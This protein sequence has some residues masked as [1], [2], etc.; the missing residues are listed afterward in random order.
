M[1]ENLKDPQKSVLE[2]NFGNEKQVEYVPYSRLAHSPLKNVRTKKATG[3]EGLA[4]SIFAKG[5]LQ[6]LVVHKLDNSHAKTA[7]LGVCAGARRFAALELL[8]AAGKIDATF[9]VPV[10]VVSPAEALAASLIENQQR[11]PM[12]PAD[13]AEAFAKLIA[14]GKSLD[15]VAA[16]FSVSAMTVQRRIKLAGISPKLTA[17]FRNDEITLEQI[18]A[19]AMTDDHAVQER[20]WFDAKDTWQRQPDRLRSAITNEEMSVRGKLVKFIGLDA[21]EFAG[22]SV[23]RDLFSNEENTGFIMDVEL[24]QNLVSEKLVELAEQVR[25]EG[26]GWAETRIERDFNEIAK[27]GRL[28]QNTKVLTAEQQTELDTLQAASDALTKK[29]SDLDE[30]DEDE[31]QEIEENIDLANAAIERFN[32]SL[33][34]FDTTAMTF[35]G[36]FIIISHSGEAVIE[37]GLVKK[38]NVEDLQKCN[39]EISGFHSQTS[40]IDDAPKV[41]ALHGEKLCK[42]LT[43]HRTAALQVELAARPDVALAVLLHSMVPVVFSSE[44]RGL[45]NMQ[46]AQV[47]GDC[48]HYNLTGN[49]DDMEGS[50]AWELIAVDRKEWVDQLPKNFNELMLWLLQQEQSMLLRLLAFCTAA[51]VSGISGTDAAHPINVISNVVELDMNKYWKPT[52][53]SYF[54]HVTKGRIVDVV[55]AAVSPEAAADLMAMKK[56]DAAAAAEIRLASST[57][58]PEVLTNRDITKCHFH[59]ASREEET[60]E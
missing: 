57:W 50:T 21:Y 56:G 30:E 22:G 23:R 39:S 36:A 7:P 55:S 27:F 47:R 8:F 35:A 25:S 51:N 52:R 60:E 59:V 43:A 9:P 1:S 26:W 16:L 53:A 41:K 46:A 42:R 4:D 49:A 37:R 3:I 31:F 20:L 13:Q 44:Y 54:D 29:Q 45:Y 2:T 28:Q 10:K 19:L 18:I 14:E 58:L 6:N 48:V 33:Q 40:S 34:Y 5:L 24:L 32:E 38:E 12:H 17:L 11:E 15:Y